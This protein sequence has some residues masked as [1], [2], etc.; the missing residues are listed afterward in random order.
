MA[1]PNIYNS[2][3]GIRQGGGVPKD[4]SKLL[5]EKKE[6]LAM[7]FANL[8]VQSLITFYAIKKHSKEKNRY[9]DLGV[10]IGLFVVVIVL[11]IISM[12]IWMKFLLFSI[13]SYGWGYILSDVASFDIMYSAM[14]GTLSIFGLMF[15]MGVIMIVSGIR[16]GVKTA[17][18]LFY[19]LLALILVT[20]F[21][22]STILSIIGIVLFSVYIIYDTNRILQKNYYGDFI[23]ASMDYYLDLLNVFVNMVNL[24]RD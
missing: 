10:W 3:W 21:T 11:S 15:A 14:M 9:V 8:I 2:F 24:N 4:V 19:S 12:P 18:A 5:F 16:L 13:F 23:T 6:F 17:I 1:N 7:I 20:L 22:T